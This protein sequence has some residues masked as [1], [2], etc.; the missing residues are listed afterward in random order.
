MLALPF[1]SIVLVCIRLTLH[2]LLITQL[3]AGSI[4]RTGMEAINPLPEASLEGKRRKRR[5]QESEI[6]PGT[7]Y[8][9]FIESKEKE[10]ARKMKGKA[11]RQLKVWKKYRK[12]KDQV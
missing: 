4:A 10:K 2:E 5:P 6:L 7:A 3:L 1:V 12:K 11:E 9:T 8:K